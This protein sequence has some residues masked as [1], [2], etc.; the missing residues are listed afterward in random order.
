LA[1]WREHVV[2]TDNRIF[3]IWKGV[4]NDGGNTFEWT[5]IT[6]NSSASNYRP[7]V[8]HNHGYYTHVLWFQRLW[9]SNNNFQ[10]SGSSH[11]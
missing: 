2:L 8:S 1:T 5:V 11:K 7:Y 6:T 3:E 9:T 4:T 10:T